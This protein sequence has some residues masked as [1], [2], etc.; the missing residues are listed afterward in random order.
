MSYLPSELSSGQKQRVAIARALAGNPA[1]VLGDEPTAALDGSSAMGVMDLLRARVTPS[2]G[3]LVVTHDHRLERYA[4]RTIA[5][6][7][8]VIRSDTIH[9]QGRQ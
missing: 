9:P 8:G 2:T 5:I 6:E 1:I 3:V 7:D 4:H